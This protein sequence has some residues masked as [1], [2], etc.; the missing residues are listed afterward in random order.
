[1]L[2]FPYLLG[3]SGYKN[4][5]SST[6][7]QDCVFIY[8]I[9]HIPW[10]SATSLTGKGDPDSSVAPITKKKFTTPALGLDDVYFTWG[11]QQIERISCGAFLWSGYGGREGN[12]RANASHLCED[13][14]SR[15]GIL[16]GRGVRPATLT[17]NTTLDWRWITCPNPRI[18]SIS[19]KSKST[20]KSTNC[21]RRGQKLRRRIK[22]SAVIWS[23]STVRHNWRPNSIIWLDGNRPR[24]VSM[25]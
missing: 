16:D 12:G 8:W 23:F 9:N 1:M 11:S 13:W 14:S 22:A 2:N 20:P 3:S 7:F 6:L 10:E 18:G 24:L 25:S 5:V 4:Y 21:T 17:T 15:S 19:W